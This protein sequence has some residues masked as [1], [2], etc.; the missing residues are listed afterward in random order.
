MMENT[1]HTSIL[2][3]ADDQM[4]RATCAMLHS[5]RICSAPDMRL[6]HIEAA[7][8]FIQTAANI[9]GRCTDTSY[10]APVDSWIYS[11]LLGLN[12]GSQ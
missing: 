1:F 12:F 4:Y 10:Y 5:D 11:V 7:T 6:P 9:F 2:W 8:N 3:L